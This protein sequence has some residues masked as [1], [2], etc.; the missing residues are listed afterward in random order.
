M[1]KK[2][3]NREAEK[4]EMRLTNILVK[5]QGDKVNQHIDL[6]SR[7]MTKVNK[8]EVWITLLKSKKFFACANR[9]E[10]WLNCI[11]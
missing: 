1:A 5:F 8:L 4:A 10:Q 9:A 7:K 11:A 6:R 3:F 2:E